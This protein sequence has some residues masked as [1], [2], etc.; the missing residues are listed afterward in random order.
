MYFS[1]IIASAFAVVLVTTVSAQDLPLSEACTGCAT[2]SAIAA[3]PT[4]DIGILTSGKFTFA[5]TPKDKACFCPLASSDAWI[6]SCQRPLACSPAEVSVTVQ[7]FADVRAAA[8]EGIVP[9]GATATRPPGIGA[10]PGNPNPTF[11]SV[12]FP[13]M[14]VQG[15]SGIRLGDSSKIAAGAALA[16]ASAV[17]LF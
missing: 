11:S 10:M 5:L 6:R 8:C 16:V 14:K 2:S 4:C 17:F 13:T 15:S 7:S 1:T 3:S 9:P 12:P